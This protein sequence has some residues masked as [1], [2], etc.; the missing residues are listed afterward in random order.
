MNEWKVFV[1]IYISKF[2]AADVDGNLMLTEAELAP[3]IEDIHGIKDLIA[4]TTMWS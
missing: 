4:N 3:S 1:E 2:N